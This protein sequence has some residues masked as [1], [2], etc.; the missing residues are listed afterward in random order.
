M[1]WI[2]MVLLLTVKDIIYWT[3]KESLYS[4][5]RAIYKSYNRWEWFMLRQLRNDYFM[6]FAE[7]IIIISILAQDDQQSIKKTYQ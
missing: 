7:I 6:S 3:A 1:A 2:P 4:W 5:T